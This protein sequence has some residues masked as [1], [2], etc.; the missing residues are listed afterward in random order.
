[1]AL[2]LWDTLYIL[3]LRLESIKV[4]TYMIFRTHVMAPGAVTSFFNRPLIG[5]EAD[6]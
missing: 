1:M 6:I 4:G 3:S 2:D 5:P